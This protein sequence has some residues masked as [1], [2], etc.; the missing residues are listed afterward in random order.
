MLSAVPDADFIDPPLEEG[1]VRIP[2]GLVHEVERNSVKDASAKD[3]GT[4]KRLVASLL[5]REHRRGLHEVARRAGLLLH[6][7]DAVRGDET[8]VEGLRDGVRVAV[9][10]EREMRAVERKGEMRPVRGGLGP[11]ERR[12]AGISRVPLELAEEEPVLVYAE[13]EVGPD[14]GGGVR[15][16]GPGVVRR[17]LEHDL[18]A[19]PPG[20]PP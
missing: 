9:H 7:E 8:H 15:E 13:A 10:V 19:G 1:A 6:H 2:L 4:R 12:R 16:A 11:D 5:H 20:P 18:L 17:A 3:G 14:D